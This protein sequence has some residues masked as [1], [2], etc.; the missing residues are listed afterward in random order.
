MVTSIFLWKRK[1]NN[2]VVPNWIVRLV[3]E[4]PPRDR[5]Q[6]KTEE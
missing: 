4:K 6:N 5:R 3:N 2:I 1:M